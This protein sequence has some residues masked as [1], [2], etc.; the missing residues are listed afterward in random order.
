MVANLI[1]TG[2]ASL[3]IVLVASD[4]SAQRGQHTSLAGTVTDATGA[5]LAGVRLTIRS[6][7]LIGGPLTAE[8]DASGVYRFPGLL[9]G[10]YALTAAHPGFETQDRSDIELPVGVG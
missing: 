8:S 3:F 6:P 5:V 10:S 7:Q 2:A 1:R 9:P 4:V